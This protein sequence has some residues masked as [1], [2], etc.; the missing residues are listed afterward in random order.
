[1]NWLA[2]TQAQV[3]AINA[4]LPPKTRVAPLKDST[5]ALFL[6]ADLLTDCEPGQTYAEAGALIKALLPGVPVLA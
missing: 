4:A 5:N 2:C 3:N 1:M 6:G